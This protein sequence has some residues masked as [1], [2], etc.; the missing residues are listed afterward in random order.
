LRRGSAS[1]QHPALA[2]NSQ[3]RNTIKSALPHNNLV[4][5]YLTTVVLGR[6]QIGFKGIGYEVLKILKLR[7]S[8]CIM[9]SKTIGIRYDRRY[10][11]A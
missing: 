8:K 1:L 9:I 10:S 5:N 6:F 3:R 2:T 7:L 4:V 11:I